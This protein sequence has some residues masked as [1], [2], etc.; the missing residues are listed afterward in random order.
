M[1]NVKNVLKALLIIIAIA[2]P[3]AILYC[4]VNEYSLR[5]LSFVL[6]L[7]ILI[8]FTKIRSYLLL[9]CGLLLVALTAIYNEKIF[10]KLYP[11]IMNSMVCLLFLCSLKK[12]PLITFFAEK[13]H[14]EITSEVKKYTKNATLAWGIFMLFNAIASFLTIFAP[15]W[16][17]AVY[18]GFISYILIGIMFLAELLYRRKYT[19][20]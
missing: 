4:L 5:Y 11:T 18:N 6:L 15:D 17:W 10:L 7:P 3:F 16:I 19:N 8:N 13:M 14:Y 9:G 1:N 20:A 12:K 2:Y